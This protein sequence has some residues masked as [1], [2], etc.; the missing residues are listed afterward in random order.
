VLLLALLLLLFPPSYSLISS[1]MLTSALSF[2]FVFATS[3]G[4]HVS[5]VGSILIE[6]DTFLIIA[7][8]SS[9][10][11]CVAGQCLQGVSNT[12]SASAT[13]LTLFLV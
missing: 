12:T 9:S 11:V 13:V 2:A 8:Q 7:A 5:F 4:E 6:A 3:V 10:V 1:I